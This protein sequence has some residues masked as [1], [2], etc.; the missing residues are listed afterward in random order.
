MLRAGY[1][2]GSVALDGFLSSGRALIMAWIFRAGKSFRWQTH[3]AP[4]V[5]VRRLGERSRKVRAGI[6]KVACRGGRDGQFGLDKGIGMREFWSKFDG[7]ALTESGL[8]IK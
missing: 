8:E 4:G 2:L 7:L 3:D 5:G 6:R 1:Q